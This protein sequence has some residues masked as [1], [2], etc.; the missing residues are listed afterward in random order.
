MEEKRSEEQQK[1]RDELIDRLTPAQLV[2][3][4]IEMHGIKHTLTLIGWAINWGIR[5]IENGPEFRAKLEEQGLS[6]ATAYRASLD[7]KRLG[8]EL[9][10]RFGVPVDVETMHQQVV[11]SDLAEYYL[12][13]L[14]RKGV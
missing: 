8:D 4:M 5:G 9:E 10:R 1:R 3:V 11:K 12:K 14:R 13:D 7:Y 6:R 2:G